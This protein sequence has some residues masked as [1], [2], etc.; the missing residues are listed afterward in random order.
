MLGFTQS[1]QR[2]LNDFGRFYQILPGSYK[3]DRFIIVKGIDK[4]DLKSDCLNGSIVNDCRQA[5]LY[6]FVL[7]EPPDR[8]NY[9]ESK[10]ELL[11]KEIN[12]FCPI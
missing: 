5:I 12:L 1:R 8:K 11:E 7:D 6:S 3:S 2:S 10:I 4:V 9:K